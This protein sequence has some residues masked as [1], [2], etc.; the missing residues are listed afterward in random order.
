[1]ARCRR[2]PSGSWCSHCPAHR[3]LTCRRP[4]PSNGGPAKSGRLP[5]HQRMTPPGRAGPRI[6]WK[7][8]TR[9]VGPKRLGPWP[10]APA[11][12]RPAAPTGDVRA[13]RRVSMVSGRAVRQAGASQEVG[14]AGCGWL[15]TACAQRRSVGVTSA[16]A[17]A[18]RWPRGFPTARPL[19]RRCPQPLSRGAA[20]IRFLRADR[21]SRARGSRQ[22]PDPSLGPQRREGVRGDGGGPDRGAVVRPSHRGRRERRQLRD[23]DTVPDRAGEGALQQ[24]QFPCTVVMCGQRCSQPGRRPT[25]SRLT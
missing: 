19:A 2:R 3:R 1:M 21:C 4:R 7:G 23:V 14:L 10:A 9:R 13:A 25:G 24:L 20:A 5:P 8:V 17:S 11:R 18:M 22:R 16:G 15:D 6:G 12:I